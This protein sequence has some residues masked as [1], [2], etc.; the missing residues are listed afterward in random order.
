MSKDTGS[1]MFT[2]CNEIRKFEQYLE[3]E[4]PMF[5]EFKNREENKFKHCFIRLNRNGYFDYSN[6]SIG[7]I[8][9]PN[10]G[11]IYSDYGSTDLHIPLVNILKLYDIW[12]KI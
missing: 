8:P 4:L 12:V 11:S 10:G 5:K 3:N 9:I 7:Y 1:R 2:N 6:T